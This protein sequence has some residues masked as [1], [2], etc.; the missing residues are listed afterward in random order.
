MLIA[1]FKGK[2]TTV[3]NFNGTMKSSSFWK[4]SSIMA[5]ERLLTY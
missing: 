5:E 1:L 2:K 4:A 3:F